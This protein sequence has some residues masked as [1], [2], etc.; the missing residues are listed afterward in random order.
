M[1][2]FKKE[3]IK[4]TYS[5]NKTGRLILVNDFVAV[6]VSNGGIQC[7]EGCSTNRCYLFDGELAL[8]IL[9]YEMC[10]P[11]ATRDALSFLET[12]YIM[13]R[14]SDAYVQWIPI[15]TTFTIAN[16]EGEEYIVEGPELFVA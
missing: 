9:E 11:G 14:W 3:A 10:S 8:F 15:G 4:N 6:V 12:K 2:A 5:F 1:E 13:T 7:R 16:N